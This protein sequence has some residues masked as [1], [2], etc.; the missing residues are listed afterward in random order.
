MSLRRHA[1]ASRALIVLALAA[2]TVSA[3]ATAPTTAKGAAGATDPGYGR[4][5]PI[6]NPTEDER[7][8][9]PRPVP[10]AP[11]PAPPRVASPNKPPPPTVAK[12]PPANGRDPIKARALR[13]QG[14]EQLNKGAIGKAQDLLRQALRLDPG[15][16]L[17][18]R[19]LDRAIR[20]GQAV[21]AKP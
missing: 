5:A 18:Q 10:R 19:D 11:A 2:L 13:A 20:I 12:P 16:A 21:R 3:C 15:N 7:A 6:P 14:L 4:M 8:A 17:I 9:A 1:G